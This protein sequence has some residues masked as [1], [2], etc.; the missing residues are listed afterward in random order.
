MPQSG[1]SRET[2]PTCQYIWRGRPIYFK[3]SAHMT[4]EASSPEVCRT[5]RKAGHPGGISVTAC[6]G[7][8]L[9]GT[10]GFCSGGL[11]SSEADCMRP[12]HVTKENL[13]H[14]K[15]TL[16][17]DTNHTC[18]IPSWQHLESNRAVGTV[19]SPSGHT[20]FN[21]PLSRTRKLKLREAV[22]TVEGHGAHGAHL[23]GEHKHAP[24]SPVCAWAAPAPPRGT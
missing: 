23:G 1:F 21:G 3:E 17:V 19:A 8:P 16:S 10:L 2:E 7:S 14:F 4:V 20:V 24:T 15:S 11:Q 12:T 22:P 18:K 13:L 6:G 5:G 9:P